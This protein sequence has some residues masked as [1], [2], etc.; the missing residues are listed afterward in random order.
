MI[1][2][3]MFENLDFKKKSKTQKIEN[4]KSKLGWEIFFDYRKI[5]KELILLFKNKILAL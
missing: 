2:P 3:E 4:R 5:E 1:F